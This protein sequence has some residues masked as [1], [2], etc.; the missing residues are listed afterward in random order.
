VT[1]PFAG[2]AATLPFI[3][4]RV[5]DPDYWW[6]VRTGQWMVDNHAFAR[7]D[8]YTYTIAGTPWTDHEYLSQLLFYALSRIGGLLAVSVFFGAVVWGGFLVILARIRQRAFSPIVAAATLI[9]GAGAGFPVWGPRPQMFDFLFAGLELYWLER[10]L[11]GR[12]RSIWFLPLLVVLWAN[13]HGGFVF[14][15]FFLALAIVALLVRRII[16][17]DTAHLVA[18]RTLAVIAVLSGV[19]ALLTPYGPS[20][21]VYVWRTQFSSQ[22]S[23]FVREWQSPD[24][25]MVSMLPF[26]LMVLAVLTGFAWRRPQLHDVLFVLGT[27]VLAM[28]AWLFIPM[29]VVAAAPVIAWEWSDAWIRLRDRLEATTFGQVQE[30]RREAELMLL[31][32][33]A[34]LGVG[35]AVYTLRGQTAAT[36]VNYPVAAAD[37][38]AAHPSVGTRM[39][40]EYSWG[41][42]LA[43][44]FYPEQS[45]RVFIY[46][47]SELMGDT[48][49]A[50]YADINNLRPDWG[51]LLDEYR[52]DY[53]I[54]PTGTPLVGALDGSSQWHRAYADSLAVIFVRGGAGGSV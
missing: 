54:F 23:T 48:L 27:L 22:L 4:R 42:Y 14:A 17:G 19:A 5:G 16:D 49:L 2:L 18:A 47:E 36:K 46:G 10:F 13:L 40:N 39:L 37:W 43:W 52:V 9:L 38:L 11:S 7:M 12:G 24:F 33:V 21:F 6:H 15:F 50:Q 26:G 8:L 30:W 35:F 25:H 29:F 32:V 45:R 1:L 44:R 53:I 28:R 51:R 3:V 20:L 31:A 34:L 41:G